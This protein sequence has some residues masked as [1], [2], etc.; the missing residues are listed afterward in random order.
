MKLRGVLW[1]DQ[2]F[3]KVQ[4]AHPPYLGL[5]PGFNIDIDQLNHCRERNASIAEQ[6]QWH[7][8]CKGRC[9]DYQLTE[10]SME[11]V[12]ILLLS[13]FF[14]NVSLLEQGM[15]KAAALGIISIWQMV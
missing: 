2:P 8:C 5:R 4:R 14:L 6:T 11:L 15:L 10:S 12:E 9:Y 13:S 7:S 1:L 3:L